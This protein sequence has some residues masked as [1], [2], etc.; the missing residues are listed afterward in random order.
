[1]KEVN[2]I[3]SHV[4]GSS[5]TH[6]VMRN[7]IRALIMDKGL[8]SFCLTINPADVYNPLVK[9]LAG[10]DIDIDQ[11]L[12]EQVPDHMEQSILVAKNP[13]IAAQFFNIYLK[14]FLKMVLGYNPSE[15]T[16][17]SSVLGPVSAHY[18]CVEAQGR[19]TLHCH[20]MI[21]LKGSVWKSGPVRSGFLTPRAIDQDRN[22]SFYFR[23]SK[24]TGPN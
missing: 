14:A 21:W 23:I 20:M 12:S 18:G 22:W 9:F 13:F 6:V 7:E 10:A 3:N 16:N 11:L 2:V 19:G 5:A 15:T 4:P 24:K 17:L 1:M 8:P